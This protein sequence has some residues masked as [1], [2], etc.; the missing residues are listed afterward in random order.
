M[1]ENLINN[2]KQEL[3]KLVDDNNRK[4]DI[5]NLQQYSHLFRKRLVSKLTDEFIRSVDFDPSSNSKKLKLG[6]DYGILCKLLSKT[7]FTCITRRPHVA[8]YEKRG[9]IVIKTLFNIYADIKKNPNFMLL[10]PD[11]RPK[12]NE[13][14]KYIDSDIARC[15]IDYIGGMMDTFAIAEFE[16]LT[17]IKFDNI[18]ISSTPDIYSSSDNLKIN[19]A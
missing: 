9:E 1:L 11:Y 19:I 15:C 16:R 2:I 7:I 14:E 6:G 8:L 17:G 12:K 5:K 4:W 3:Y 18:D 13:Q 10:P